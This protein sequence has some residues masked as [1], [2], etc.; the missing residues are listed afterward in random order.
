VS[1]AAADSPIPPGARI[2][3][4]RKRVGLTQE[5]CAQLKGCT[6]SAWRKWESGDRQVAAF[7]DWIEI[8][9][10]L[11][12]RDLYKLTGLPVGEL[13]EEPTEHDTVPAIR[14]AMVSFD[15]RLAGEPDVARLDRAIETAWDVW[16][17]R[18][19]YTQTGVTLPGL[20]TEVRATIPV[21][22]G[23][24]RD[25]LLRAASMLY[26]LTRAFTKR[27]WAGDVS[28]LAADRAMAAAIKVDDLDFRAAAAWNLGMTLSE[29]G[30]AEHV[31]HELASDAAAT[32]EPTLADGPPVRMSVY[33]A[34]HLL[35]AMQCARLGDEHG[36]V[37]GLDTAERVA[38]RL[39]D[40][41][42]FR[43]VFG[44]TNVAIHR[45]WA[46]VEMSRPGEAIRH[47]QRCDVSAVPS[48]ERRFFYYV[49]LA[50]AYCIRNEDVAAV[51]ML[52]RA[53]RESAED[54]RFSVEVRAM[55]RELLRR[56]SPL[57]RTE[58]RPLADRIGI[59]H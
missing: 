44:P 49:Q 53:E 52:L 5:Q 23:P 2:R 11:R 50:R 39:G 56:E 14:A 3:L 54:L 26:F 24:Q 20:I 6:V 55:V 19:P 18:R 34:L 33:G 41:N 16:Q 38:A 40:R 21:V 12:V 4:Y 27:V 28:L 13:H 47:A 9:K 42:D 31:V 35:C 30:Q 15:P 22:D 43:T 58:L 59:L 46:A 32:L 45:V 36:V 57:T 1:S 48:V 7:S 25:R 10:I 8:A 29:R 37:R 51:H 17:E